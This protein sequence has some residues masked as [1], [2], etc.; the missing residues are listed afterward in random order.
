MNPAKNRI[1]V[2]GGL[3]LM[4]EAALY[5]LCCSPQVGEILVLDNCRA[6]EAEVLKKLPSRSKVKI[7]TADLK[8][9][10]KTKK[11]L[12]G[13]KVLVH[14]AWYELNLAAMDIALAIGAHYVDLGGLYYMTLKQLKKNNEFRGRA[15][16]AVLGCGS[17]PGIANVMARF[18]TDPMQ[19]VESLTIYDAGHD[20][21]L[22]DQEFLPPFSIR[23]LLD[24]FEKP[25][26]IYE[27][28]RILEDP[29]FSYEEEV[30]FPEPVGKG[31]AGVILHSELATLPRALKSKGLQNLFFK[32][33]YPASVKQ[34]MELLVHVGFAQDSAVQVNG[35]QI[36]P[37]EFITAMAREAVQ[38]APPSKPKDYEI[39]RVRVTG[40]EDRLP[41]EKFLDVHLR[42]KGPLSAGAMGVGFTASIVTQM[43]CSGEILARGVLAPEAAV[44]P[45]PFFRQW[46]SRGVFEMEESRKKRVV[47]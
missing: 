39:L 44:P 47:V 14:C 28:G 40:T 15:L 18:L 17:T 10:D 27:R 43:L 6:R 2:L 29:P 9:R 36:S 38:K 20:P 34:Q 30:N 41:V 45:G 25:A 11:I 22:N 42:S 3:G 32:I 37:R 8:D 16:T 46:K 24:E 5:D 35:Y 21:A 33:I 23:T 13:S 19:R 4:G 31:R 1:A 7:L 12:A 26:V